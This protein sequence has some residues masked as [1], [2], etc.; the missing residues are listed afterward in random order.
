MFGSSRF[1]AP[2]EFERG[3][4]IDGRTNGVHYG[5][6]R[7]GAAVGRYVGT[8]SVSRKRRIVRGGSPRMLQG[9]GK[10]IRLDDS[11]FCCVDGRT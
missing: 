5:K 8:P 9:Y 4:R 10:T 1:M 6:N 11:L 7:S 3:A 2:E